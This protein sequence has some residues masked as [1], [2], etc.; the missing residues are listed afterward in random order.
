MITTL[1]TE[2][3]AIRFRWS[4]KFDVPAVYC[5]KRQ[6][7]FFPN[8]TRYYEKNGVPV[9]EIQGV[10]FDGKWRQDN[11]YLSVSELNEIL[12]FAHENKPE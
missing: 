9:N 7:H 8:D 12:K 5:T 1:L 11:F 2:R 3:K 6:V 4:Y 10:Y